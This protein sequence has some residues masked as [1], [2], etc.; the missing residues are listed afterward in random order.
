MDSTEKQNLALARIT[1]VLWFFLCLF[2]SLAAIGVLFFQLKYPN[3]ELYLQLGI[4]GEAATMIIMGTL[5]LGQAL[6]MEKEPPLQ[7]LK[8]AA[9][10]FLG[11]FGALLLLGGFFR[12]LKYPNWELFLQLGLTG[13]AAALAVTGL[14]MLAETF[15]M[16]TPT[17]EAGGIGSEGGESPSPIGRE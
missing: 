6:Q 14:L 12:M 7:R 13:T 11:I 10:F 2:G 16:D 1:G 17:E 8:R 3:W 9:G 4:I 15:T 5:Q